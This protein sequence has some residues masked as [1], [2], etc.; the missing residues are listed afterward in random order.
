MIKFSFCF[1][2]KGYWLQ[3]YFSVLLFFLNVQYH[4]DPNHTANASEIIFAEKNSW[5]NTDSHRLASTESRP[6]YYR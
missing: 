6:E 5:L 1:V 3:I 4:N 2:I